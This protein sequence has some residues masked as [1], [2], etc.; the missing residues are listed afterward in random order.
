MFER[1]TK[2]A[3]DVVLGAIGQA[4]RREDRRIR[5]EHLLLSV[6]EISPLLDFDE[7]DTELRR[8]DAEALR[9]VG[10]DPELASLDSQ[11]APL[12][13]KRLPFTS[14]AK[15]VLTNSLREALDRGDREIGV[16]HILLALISLDPSERAIKA[17]TASGVDPSQLRESLRGRLAS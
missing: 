1:F 2:E 6:A 12:R 13:K 17:L 10:I 11:R 5:T 9:L 15:K 8:L 7:I 16:T 14:E 4:E 3:R